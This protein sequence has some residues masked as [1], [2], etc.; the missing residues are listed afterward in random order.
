MKTAAR[1]LYFL[2]PFWKQTALSVLLGVATI[3][4][5]IGLLG[6]SAYLIAYAALQ[7][8]ISVLQVAIVGVRFFGISRAVARYL[9]R[10]VSHSVNFRLLARLRV[11]F[12]ERIEPLAPARL[13]GYRSADLLSRAIDDIETLE[14]FYVRAVAPPVVAAVVVAG[15]GLFVGRYDWRF[16]ILLVAALAAGGVGLPL[17]LHGLSRR[18][19]R[20]VVE[21]RAQL[22]A[23]LLDV[24]QG[25]PDLLA[26]GQSAAQ[27]ERIR[28]AGESY[29]A[30][31]RGVVRAGALGNSVS[32]LLTGFALW[33]MLLL[34]IPQVGVGIDGITLAVLA[35]ITLSSFEAVTPLSQAAQHLNSS[36]Q[37]ASRLFNL[38]DVEPP[39]AAPSRSQAEAPVTPDAMALRIR[40]LSFSYGQND[41]PAL[42]DFDLD[43]PPGKH[44]ALVGSSGAGKTTLF[45]LLLRFWEYEQGEIE[46]DG[47]PIRCYDPEEIRRRI[48]VVS[49]STYLFTGTLRQNLQLASPESSSADI[50]RV[51][52][53]S[54]LGELVAQ[55]PDGLDTW[56]GERGLQ[57]SGGERQRVAVARALLKI[58]VLKSS[59]ALLLLDEP[60]ANLDAA[61]E[62]ILLETLREVSEGRSLIHITHRLV[63]LESMDE[64]LVLQAGR[65]IERGTHA[66]L[67]A[68]NG[69]YAEMLA[70]QNQK[71]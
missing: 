3:A 41:V 70:I 9:E 8:S 62:R 30:A 53:Q 21:R 17:L 16:S 20:L 23:S 38:V 10:L 51:L 36:L 66:Q 11:W 34:A 25:M 69:C 32:L 56:I 26:Y 6:T 22:N 15:V 63:G 58:S 12:Y 4:S 49:Q 54:R 60:T 64:I 18:P 40:R 59:G 45:N 14:N 65:V 68:A 27:L 44:V 42:A 43:L 1:L 39:V 55:L 33:G 28:T 47:R 57:L 52:L 5:G 37:S 48:A 29:G 35:L 24:I 50:E 61:N 19:G 7:P 71:I 2:R 67:L 13:M 31:Q 46:L